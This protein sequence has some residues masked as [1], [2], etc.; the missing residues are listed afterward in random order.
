MAIEA[1]S[2]LSLDVFNRRH[3]DRSASHSGI[4]RFWYLA[5]LRLG[6]AKAMA[7]HYRTIRSALVSS[8]SR[9]LRRTCD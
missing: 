2:A 8:S 1:R 5:I 6:G 3:L 4:V 7:D 9:S